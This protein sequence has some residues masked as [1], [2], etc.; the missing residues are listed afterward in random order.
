M[1]HYVISDIHG[2]AERFHAM[3]EKI[4]FSDADTLYILGDVA[5]RGPDGI[6]LLRQIQ[7]APNMVLIL[8]NHDH[9]LMR[10]FS[11]DVTELEIRRWNKNRNAD[12]KSGYLKL[13]AKEQQELMEYLRSSPTHEEVTVNGRRF[14]LV[15]GFPGDNLHDEIWHRP[16]LDTPNPIPGA[17]VIIGHTPVQYILKPDDEQRHEYLADLAGREEHL[18]ILHAP[19]FIDID[20]SCGYTLTVRALACIRL[21]N[22]EEF[23]V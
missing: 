12:T 14:Y 18:R 11:P 22:M 13:K 3:L 23:Y 5:D 1:A 19:G 20:C 8:G 10:Y 9:M 6:D 4:G 7:S 17:T 16:E 2:E 15:H 21:E